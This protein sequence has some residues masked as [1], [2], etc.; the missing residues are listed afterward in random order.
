MEPWQYKQIEALQKIINKDWSY[1]DIG[2]ARGEMLDFFAKSMSGGYA[3][4]PQPENYKYLKHTFASVNNLE[5]IKKAVSNTN[6]TANFWIHPTSTH[7]GNLLGHDTAYKQYPD[8]N[9]IEV[10]C[11]TLDSFIDKNKHI[12]LIKIDVEGAEWKIFEGAK[13]TLEERDIVY[14]VEFHLDED[15][16]KRSMLYDYGYS[17]YDLSFNRLNKEDSRL[18]QTLLIKDSDH[19]FDSIIRL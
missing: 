5:I 12:D 9:K 17:I 6:E 11:I 4:E 3:F 10:E 19:R 15:W 8:S 2:G 13:N 1:I 7:E 14:Q 18:Y 16:H